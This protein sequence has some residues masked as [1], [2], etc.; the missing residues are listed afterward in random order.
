LSKFIVTAPDGSQYE[1]DAPEGASENDAI[2]YLQKQFSSE[3]GGPA[4]T[5][6][7]GETEEKPRPPSFM[8]FAV[9]SAKRGLTGFPSSL[10]S[11]GAQ[12]TGTFAGAFPT[13]PEM[14]GLTTENI[15]RRMGVDTAMRPATTAQKYAG[16][17]I[18]AAFDPTTILGGPLKVGSTGLRMGLATIPGVAMLLAAEGSLSVTPD[19]NSRYMPRVAKMIAGTDASTVVVLAIKP[20]VISSFSKTTVKP[21]ETLIVTGNYFLGA[22]SVT[23]DGISVPYTVIDETSIS[24]AIPSNVRTGSV[25]IKN[26]GVSISSVIFKKVFGLFFSSTNASG[27]S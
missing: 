7:M 26:G 24:I 23:L 22:T 18:E 1:V 16:A 21:G 8:E 14:L 2:A 11:G 17:G 27:W 3:G 5:M 10:T 6:L 20:P 4:A 15:Q 19:V 13:Q 25:Q 12:Q 9:E